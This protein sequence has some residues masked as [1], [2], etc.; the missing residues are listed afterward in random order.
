[1]NAFLAWAYKAIL[2]HEAVVGLFALAFIITMRPT[3]PSPFCRIEI[4]EW[5]YEWTHDALKTFVS[6]RSPQQ[7]PTAA[8]PQ[9]E[10]P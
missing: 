3:L 5:A 4:L 7:P 10:Q 6:F 9:K 2:E 1:V 8:Q